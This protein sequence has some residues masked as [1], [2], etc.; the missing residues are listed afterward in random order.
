VPELPEPGLLTEGEYLE[1]PA[2]ERWEVLLPEGREGVVVR[3]LVG[4]E[5]TVGDL[6]VGRRLDLAGR[7]CAGAAA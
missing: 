2:R 7:R 6:L 1:E 4:R 5:H 3:V